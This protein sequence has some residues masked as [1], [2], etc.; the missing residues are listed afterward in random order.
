MVVSDSSHALVTLSEDSAVLSIKWK[1][2]PDMA[3]F[4]NLYWQVLQ[5]VK[6]NAKICYY[7]TDISQIGPFDPDQEA[8]LSREYYPKVLDIIGE[9]IY[10]AVVFSEGHFKALVSNYIASPLLTPSDFIHFNYF[11]DNAEAL[12]WLRYMQKGQDLAS[13]ATS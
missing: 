9:N 7:N 5:F 13:V 8:W 12:D 3:H 1:A 4:R 6:A 11:T 10:A 2:K